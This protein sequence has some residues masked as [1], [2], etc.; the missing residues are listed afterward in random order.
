MHSVMSLYFYFFPSN[1]LRRVI[2]LSCD[3]LLD[4]L[5]EPTTANAEQ[6]ASLQIL[7]VRA[8]AVTSGFDNAQWS[9]IV[10]R[11]FGKV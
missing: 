7:Y 1:M 6:N 10:N 4:A 2:F 3:V 8:N 5:S 9:N 11:S